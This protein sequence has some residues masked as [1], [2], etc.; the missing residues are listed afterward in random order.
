MNSKTL[1]RDNPIAE[2]IFAHKSQRNEW[3]ALRIINSDEIF[4]ERRTD[5]L[6]FAAQVTATSGD[7]SKVRDFKIFPDI[8]QPTDNRRKIFFDCTITLPTMSVKSLPSQA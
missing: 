2:A 7:A 3:N 8:W 4:F 5:S 6:T 1:L